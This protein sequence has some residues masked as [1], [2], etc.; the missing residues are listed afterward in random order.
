M[1]TL[2]ADGPMQKGRPAKQAGGVKT[3]HSTALSRAGFAAGL[4][5]QA[6]GP[7]VIAPL[8][9]TPLITS[10]PH[11]I[12]NLFDDSPARCCVILESA[13]AQE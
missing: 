12:A 4:F 2:T 3:F 1:H 7:H 9:A 5:Q 13:W 6:P 10:P 8:G 11:M